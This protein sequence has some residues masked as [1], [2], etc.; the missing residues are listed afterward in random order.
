[1]TRI[2]RVTPYLFQ[3]ERDEPYLGE[4]R[5]GDVLTPN[6]YM[7]RGGNRTV[8]PLADRSVVLRIETSDGVTG[9]GE[10][11]GIVTP[12]AVMEI[13][14]ELF[15]PLLIGRDPRDVGVIYEDLYDLMRVRYT[16]GGFYHDALAA[17]D[18]A[19]WDVCGKLAGVSVARLL[20]GRR[21]ARVP[22]YVSGLPGPS[23]AARLELA[24]SWQERG[25]NAFKFAT[26]AVDDMVDEFRAMREGLGPDAKISADMHW[27][28]SA[29]EA[30]SLARACEPYDPWFLEAP[31]APENIDGLAVVTQGA[32]MPVAA[33]EEWRTA[34]D[35][36]ERLAKGCPDIV[37]PEMG[38]TGITQFMRMTQLAQVHHRPVIPHATIGLGIFL[39][40]S[41]QASAAA[42]NVQA[43]EFQHTIVA[44]VNRFLT[45][46]VTL[47]EGAYLIPDRPGIGNEPNADALALLKE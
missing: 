47:K 16:S 37:Q 6:G 10:T 2:E 13:I 22:G 8:Y 32:S 31:C 19:L 36:Q 1:M 41:L 9:W 27:R 43:H 33:G 28:H 34:W 30:L 23:Q 44:R 5:S 3:S 21:H 40:A 12:R 17:V 18:I 29:A 15:A 26:P 45:H 24:Q 38:H 35:L 42:R 4:M 11:Y 7:V 46:E 14:S 39:S 20:G 25:V